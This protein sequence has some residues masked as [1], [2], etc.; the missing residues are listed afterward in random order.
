M[1]VFSLQAVH[2]PKHGVQVQVWRRLQHRH[3]YAETL[4][5]ERERSS[6]NNSKPVFH[7]ALNNGI[8]I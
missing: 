7:A 8:L 4:P 1:L 6:L 3:V 2:H 5:G